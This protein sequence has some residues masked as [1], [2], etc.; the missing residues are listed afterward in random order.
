MLR[1][2]IYPYKLGSK[3]AKA[4]AEGLKDLRSKRVRENGNYRPF[5]NH[6]VLNW[7]NPRV[8]EWDRDPRITAHRGFAVR[9]LNHPSRIAVAQNKLSTYAELKG[10]CNIPEFTTDA[11]EAQRW[12]QTGSV[13]LGRAVLGGHGGTGIILIKPDDEEAPIAF[14]HCPLFVKYVKKRDEYRIHVFHHEVIDVQH[15]RKRNGFEN[16][17]YKIRN[18]NRGWVFARNDILEPNPQ[19]LEQALLAVE[20]L[21][22]D[23]GAVDIGWNAHNQQATVYEVN[24]APGVEGTTLTNYVSAIRRWCNHD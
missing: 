20:R 24:T 17:D 22:L 10:H 1:P 13:V 8:P 6:V 19:V 16:A 15:K 12:V 2:I 21:G 23:F 4:L 14:A 18:Y 9:W 5:R 7:G 3:S 11:L